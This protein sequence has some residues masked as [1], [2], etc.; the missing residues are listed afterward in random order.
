MS[1]VSI[2]GEGLLLNPTN[3][4]TPEGYSL[5]GSQF[6]DGSGESVTAIGQ[7]HF[8]DK[9]AS[10]SLAGATMW[11][12]TH[13]ATFSDGGTN[14][15]IGIQ[16]LAANGLED[17]VFDVYKDFTGGG[18]VL[19]GNGWQ[20]HVLDQGS[21]TVSHGDLLAISFE[22]TT[23]AGSDFVLVSYASNSVPASSKGFPYG[24]IDSGAGPVKSTSVLPSALLVLADGTIGRIDN[25]WSWTDPDQGTVNTTTQGGVYFVAPFTGTIDKVI[26][27]VTDS[28]ATTD[29]VTIEVWGDP[30]GTPVSI[31]SMA[32]Q[33]QN[34][35]STGSVRNEFFRFP[36][37][38]AV[39]AGLEYAIT[40]HCT[41][42]IINY[43]F[44]NLGTG[45][46]SFRK[47]TALGETWCRCQRTIP[48][49]DPFTLLDTQLPSIAFAYDTI[50]IGGGS[51]EKSFPFV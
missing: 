36:T 51:S 32:V 12:R 45:N 17:G 15:R 22:L 38:I 28:V 11:F 10:K 1:I 34:R 20:G 35:G 14:F 44:I 40:I 16:D 48:G 49:S 18:G 42:G 13:G 29:M 21:K 2:G 4:Q 30:L 31:G 37:P 46:S 27:G 50:N 24:T 25:A 5:T 43:G 7:I 19:T 33:G 41:V 39:T 6:L 47:I 23:R 9:G 3:T 8:S 26:F